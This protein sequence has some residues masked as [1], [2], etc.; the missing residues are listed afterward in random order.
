MLNVALCVSRAVS[1]T[2]D[3]LNKENSCS[4]EETRDS[5]FGLYSFLY[6]YKIEFN[7]TF[8]ANINFDNVLPMFSCPKGRKTQAVYFLLKDRPHPYC[9][10]G[11][12]ERDVEQGNRQHS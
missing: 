5:V 12:E 3:C 8:D 2:V 7:I 1:K 4:E 9:T 6:T 10:N 11:F